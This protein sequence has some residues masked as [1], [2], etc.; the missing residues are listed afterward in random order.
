MARSTEARVAPDT[1]GE[2]S[3]GSRDRILDAAERLVGER[4]YTAASISLI[5]KA[6]G[7]PASSIYWHFGSKEGLLAAV[8]ERGARRWLPAQDRWLSY[9][10]DL[11][12]FLRATGRAVSEQPEFVRLLMMLMLDRRDGVTAARDAMRAVWREVEGRMR[13]VLAEHFDLRSSKSDLELAERLA[14]FIMAC[15][16]GALVDSQ[17]DPEGT[18]IPGLFADLGVALESIAAAHRRPSEHGPERPHARGR[19]RRQRMGRDANEDGTRHTD[20]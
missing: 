17:I 6:S 16:D 12:A 2:A 11:P 20:R 8:V 10:S 13:H 15:I 19:G 1:D 3:T 18:P 14:R 7:L 9:G 4:G 5:S